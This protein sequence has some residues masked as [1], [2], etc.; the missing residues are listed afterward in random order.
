MDLT[1]GNADILP[2][3]VKQIALR[4]GIGNLLANGVRIAAEKIG[5]MAKEFAVH[6]KGLEG[7]AHDPRSGKALAITYATGSRGMC[8]IQPLEGM[9]WDRGKLD[10]GMQ[11]YGVPD[12]NT[13]ERWDE[14]GKGSVVAILQNGLV[15][16]DI[17]GTCKFYMYAGV[18]LDHMAEMLSELTGWDITGEELLTVGER[19]INLQR[20]FNIREGV[21]VQDDSLPQRVMAIPSFGK[22]SSESNC[23]IQNL[24]S[25]LREYY[26]ERDWDTMT[27]MP[28]TE[29]LKELGLA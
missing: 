9:A 8:H 5:P 23:A 17:L 13:V 4:E 14:D 16:P 3:L 1:W 6:V 12:P 10:W 24:D 18:T 29:K 20:I 22:Y 7:P 25:M 26:E 27:G 21:E 2:I 15:L 19:T 28:S 11:K